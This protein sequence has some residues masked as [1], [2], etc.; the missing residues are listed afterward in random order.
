QLKDKTD[1]VYELEEAKPYKVYIDFVSIWQKKKEVY[2]HQQTLDD[3][4]YSHTGPNAGNSYKTLSN[5]IVRDKQINDYFKQKAV[6]VLSDYQDTTR[7]DYKQYNKDSTN[8]KNRR[9]YLKPYNIRD[10]TC[11]INT[12]NHLIQITWEEKIDMLACISLTQIANQIK[13]K[14]CHEKFDI[15]ASQ[16]IVNSFEQLEVTQYWWDN[17]VKGYINHDEYAKRDTINNVNEDDF[18]WIRDKVASET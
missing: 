14:Y 4:H 2:K 8:F 1:Q 7:E 16:N 6:N 18:E 13:Y 3:Y 12:I 11:M 17:K 15:N 10:V 9:E 5:T